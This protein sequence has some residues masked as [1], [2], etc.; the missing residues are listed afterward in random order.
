MRIFLAL[1]FIGI[2]TIYGGFVGFVLSIITL[3]VIGIL[4]E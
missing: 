2:S 1:A 3:L 4:A